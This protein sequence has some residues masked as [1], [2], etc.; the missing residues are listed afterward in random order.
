MSFFLFLVLSLAT[1]IIV[2]GVLFAMCDYLED[3]LQ[4]FDGDFGDDE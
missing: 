3:F 4:P 2:M 1:I